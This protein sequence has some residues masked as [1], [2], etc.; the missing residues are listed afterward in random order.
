MGHGSQGSGCR[1]TTTTWTQFCHLNRPSTSKIGVS[2]SCTC[3]RVCAHRGKLFKLAYLFKVIKSA[4]NCLCSVH[5]CMLSSDAVMTQKDIKNHILIIY[6]PTLLQDMD[7]KRV[8]IE[9]LSITCGR[10]IHLH[11]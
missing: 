7:L 1:V 11:A 6:W 9:Y 4:G 8:L 5:G 2:C 3:M 10:G